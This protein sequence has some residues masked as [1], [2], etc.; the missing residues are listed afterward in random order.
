MFPMLYYLQKIFVRLE[1]FNQRQFLENQF[2]LLSNQQV[3]Q[4]GCLELKP[5]TAATTMT[6][7]TTTTTSLTTLTTTAAT[8]TTTTTTTEL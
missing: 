7:T 5:A 8:T 3:S 4:I 6:T 2:T 1:H